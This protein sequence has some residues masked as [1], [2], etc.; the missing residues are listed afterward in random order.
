MVDHFGEDAVIHRLFGVHPVIAFDIFHNLF[1]LLACLLGDDPRQT[2]AHD[3][4][5][6]S[7]NC[8]VCDLAANAARRLVNEETGVWQAN[9]VFLV[10]REENMRPR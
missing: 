5:L 8:N 1:K 6:F 7:L 10:D 2:G 3:F 9:T 4:D